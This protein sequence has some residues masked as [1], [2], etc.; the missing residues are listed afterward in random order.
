MDE[1]KYKKRKDRSLH[2]SGL[3]AILFDF[4]NNSLCSDCCWLSGI[5]QVPFSVLF[6]SA[7]AAKQSRLYCVQSGYVLES[8][9]ERQDGVRNVLQL[10]LELDA[11]GSEFLPTCAHPLPVLSKKIKSIINKNE[12]KK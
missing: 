3:D 5:N 4:V 11:F 10:P 9:G 8:V 6:L 1:F 12:K 7:A 2:R